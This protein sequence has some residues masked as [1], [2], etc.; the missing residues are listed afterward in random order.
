MSS[1]VLVVGEALIDVTT[2]P[3]RDAV[4]SCGGSPFNVAIGLA[5]LGIATTLATQLG[6]D[7]D[8]DRIRQTLARDGVTLIELPPK[9][10]RTSAATATL[11]PSGAAG[12]TFDVAW[13]PTSLPATTAYD[14]I[15]LGSLATVV[16]PGAETVIA[17]AAAAAA[18][19]G[20]P[21]SF[22]PNVRLGVADAA[23]H[24]RRFSQIAAF[25]RIVKLSDDDAG[26]LFPGE[27]PSTLI[28]RLAAHTPMVA[29]TLGADGAMIASGRA[30]VRAAASATTVADTIGAGDSFTAAMLAG[31]CDAGTLGQSTLPAVDLTAL[32]DSATIA[33]AIT[34]SRNGA[35]PPT[36]TELTLTRAAG[37][38]G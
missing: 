18:D 38:P 23:E 6:S 1:R 13:C 24:R 31:L 15:H 28:R 7:A 37:N 16:Q 33:A 9:P 12:Y 34:C 36:R 5:R 11:D 35:D 10:A 27:A 21:V 8:G 29:A 20:T 26:V 32:L 22:D 25:A 30:F 14:L 17:W 19:R 4:R 2:A 3:G